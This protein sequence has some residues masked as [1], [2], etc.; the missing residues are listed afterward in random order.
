MK[1]TV[2]ISIES[3]KEKIW[4]VI[5]DIE[6]S[7]NIIDGIHKIEVLEQPQKSFVGL[8]WRETRTMFGKEATEV[9]WITDAIENES[10]R[11]RAESHGAVYLT[12]FKITEHGD[13]CDLSMEFT[14]EPQSFGARIMAA[15]T[16]FLFKGATLKALKKDLED[17][18]AASEN[19]Q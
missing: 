14:G 10:Y 19:A 3:T 4:N 11:T 8:K 15:L 16:G 7:V 17:I 12:A 2:Q 1:L 5:S 13:S 6:N 18:K 9:M